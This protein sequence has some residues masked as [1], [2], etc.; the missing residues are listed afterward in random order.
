MF[1][2]LVYAHFLMF[3][4]HLTSFVGFGRFFCILIIYIHICVSIGLVW[5]GW[6]IANARTFRV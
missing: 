5:S 2:Y 1:V 6:S 3:I 4:L